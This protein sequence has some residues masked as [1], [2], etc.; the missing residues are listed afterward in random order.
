MGADSLN[1]HR[2]CALCL[3]LTALAWRGV[4]DL[5]LA[6]VLSQALLAHP[7]LF[8]AAMHMALPHTDSTT[9]IAPQCTWGCPTPIA[10]R[11]HECCSRLD[12]CV[13][14]S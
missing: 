14:S 6:L 11:Y 9:Q 8:W 5:S 1:R 4:I 3:R 10:P 12:R 2:L 7:C 13:A